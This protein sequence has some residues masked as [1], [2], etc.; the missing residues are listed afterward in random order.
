M[1]SHSELC[2]RCLKRQVDCDRFYREQVEQCDRFVENN[3]DFEDSR[4]AAASVVPGE[5]VITSAIPTGGPSVS[6][7]EQP[8][9]SIDPNT[10]DFYKSSG[11]S[12]KIN[13]ILLGFFVLAVG[14]WQVYNH[15]CVQVLSK[16]MGG[17]LLPMLVFLSIAGLVGLLLMILNRSAIKPVSDERNLK[18]FRR[19]FLDSGR[20]GCKEYAF[21]WIIVNVVELI[22]ALKIMN[23]PFSSEIDILVLC[24]IEI[25]AFPFMLTQGAKRCHDLGNSGWYQFIP[26]YFFWLMFQKPDLEPNQ[27]GSINSDAS[28]M[29][30][31]LQVLAG[32][33]IVAFIVINA[34][35][36]YF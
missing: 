11:T 15:V 4:N 33:V 25:I 14:G 17:T 16:Q 2:E 32:G 20:I 35:S 8:E 18:Y 13:K 7:D 29:P 12:F 3:T 23:D 21:S 5:G 36:K 24:L 1:S 27:Y 26:F 6:I 10:M 9:D 28:D 31:W 30:A 19:A 34:W 22:F